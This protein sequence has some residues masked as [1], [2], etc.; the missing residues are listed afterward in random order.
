MDPIAYRYRKVHRQLDTVGTQMS[1]SHQ[2]KVGDHSPLVALSARTSY[3]SFVLLIPP[4]PNAH[5]RNKYTNVL[6][7]T[8][9]LVPAVSKVLLYGFGGIFEIENI[10]SATKT[11]NSMSTNVF[12]QL[13]HR[14][15][16][17][18]SHI[19][20]KRSVFRAYIDTFRTQV[21]ICCHWRPSRRRECSQ[22]IQLAI[23]A[24]DRAPGS[25]CIATCSRFGFPL[26]TV[27]GPIVLV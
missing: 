26:T 14:Q 15:H 25:G 16:C 19:R 8:T 18:L 3:S 11:G 6:V 12:K 7:T 22:A 24:C 9:Q 13:A 5:N 21:Y 1:H 17:P 2:V 4:P 20:R 10:Y 27:A 23:L